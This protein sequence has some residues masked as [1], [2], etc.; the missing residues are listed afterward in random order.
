MEHS[1]AADTARVRLATVDDLPAIVALLRDDR[2]GATREDAADA[3]DAGASYRDAFDEISRDPQHEILVLE[4]DGAVAGVLQLSFLRCLTHRGGRRAQ[5]EGVRI[6]GVRRGGGL[7]RVLVGD[8]VRRA[9]ERGCHLVQL[10]TDRERPDAIAFYQ[11]L[12][13]AGTHH[14]MKL[15]LRG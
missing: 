14:G 10:T 5:I 7:G 8:A 9:R 4:L 6:D 15:H 12:G 3:A 2:L 1:T 13:F 11:R